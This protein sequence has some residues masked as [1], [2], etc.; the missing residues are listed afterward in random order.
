MSS[1][2]SPT[3]RRAGIEDAPA[4]ARVHVDSWRSAYRGIVPDEVLANLSVDERSQRWVR[5][6][7]G[8]NHQQVWV[9]EVDGA[10]VGFVATAPSGDEDLNPSTSGEVEAIYLIENVWRRGLGATLL[11][12]AVADLRRAGYGE[13]ALWV[14][15]RNTGARRFYEEAGWKPDGATKDCFGGVDAPALRYR[16]VL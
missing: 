8:R 14:L 11:D 4:I 3:L 16:R 7:S 2:D 12:A 15:E 13:A 1:S 9:A 6:I 10:V 5:T